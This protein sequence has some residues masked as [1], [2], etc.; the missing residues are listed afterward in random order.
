MLLMLP[1][2]VIF[3]FLVTRRARVLWSRIIPIVAAGLIL[4]QLLYLYIPLRAPH[5]PYAELQLDARRTLV[6]YENSL[7]GFLDLVLAGAFGGQLAGGS[8]TSGRLAMALDLLLQQFTW[9]GICLGG[10]GIVGVL[11]RRLWAFAALTLLPYA[12]YVLFNLVY[13]IG[14]IYV[15]FIPSY[16]IWSLWV[17]LG[18]WETASLVSRSIGRRG[19]SATWPITLIASVSF[20]LPV[21]LLFHNYSLVDQRHNQAAAQIWEPILSQDLPADSILVS[22]DRDEI[23]P[24]WYY[25]YVDGMRPGWLGMF[26]LIVRQPG[27]QDVGQV[28]DSALSS[29][30]PVFL[31]KPMPGLDLKYR[32]QTVGPSVRVLESFDGQKPA[33][34]LDITFGESIRLIGYDQTKSERDSREIVLYWEGL[35]EIDRAYSSYVHLL[36]PSGETTSGHDHRPGGDYYPTDHWKPGEVLLDRHTLSLPPGASGTYTIATGLY[37]WPSMDR[38]GEEINIGQILVDQ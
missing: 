28:V 38:L 17:G 9:S 14:D 5:V 22:N 2:L 20:V 18:V 24:M 15:L 29:N 27:Y 6:L 35:K 7:S 23:M 19:A 13:F 4:P 12:A 25:Q 8:V 1:W 32:L 11:G 31:M 16:L 37:A 10:I 3:V 33:V 30:R 34:P 21:W 26:P 36:S